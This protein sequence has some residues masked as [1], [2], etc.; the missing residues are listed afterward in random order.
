MPSYVTHAATITLTL[1]IR[2]F[3]TLSPLFPLQIAIYKDI[4]PSSA[5]KEDA[6]VCDLCIRFID[7]QLAF[8]LH[9]R[10]GHEIA[11]EIKSKSDV[12]TVE[13]PKSASNRSVLSKG[14]YRYASIVNF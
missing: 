14:K 5:A 9:K 3:Y 4:A 6:R 13:M 10:Y 7:A 1:Q 8:A 11:T 2:Y 12:P